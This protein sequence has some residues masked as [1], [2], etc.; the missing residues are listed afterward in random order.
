M[1]SVFVQTPKWSPENTRQE[2]DIRVCDAR[3]LMMTGYSDTGYRKLHLFLVLV[4]AQALQFNVYSGTHDEETQYRSPL[5]NSDGDSPT[6]SHTSHTFASP[7]VHVFLTYTSRT[8]TDN[9]ADLFDFPIIASICRYFVSSFTTRFIS[10]AEPETTSYFT[11]ARSSTILQLELCPDV[12]DSIAHHRHDLAAADV[13]YLDREFRN[14]SIVSLRPYSV[15]K[16]RKSKPLFP[17]SLV[18]RPSP[19]RPT[20]PSLE[21]RA[22]RWMYI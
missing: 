15:R 11:T 21:S 3:L 19:L 2:K 7:W 4:E 9:N 13:A 1:R 17:I 10:T 20:G 8:V 14:P 18:Y 5:K 6:E 16:K 22:C 12:A